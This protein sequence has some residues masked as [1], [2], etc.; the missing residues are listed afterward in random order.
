MSRGN[1]YGNRVA[2]AQAQ[3]YTI[4][5]PRMF[6]K[7]VEGLI[8]ST[9]AERYTYHFCARVT[10][11]VL[12]EFLS[13]S[14]QRLLS[15]VRSMMIIKDL[16]SVSLDMPWNMLRTTARSLSMGKTATPLYSL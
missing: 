15:S 13:W 10:L 4:L 2:V 16:P 3:A 6:P 7:G 11:V 14:F 9:A 12:V 8:H 1:T 5:N